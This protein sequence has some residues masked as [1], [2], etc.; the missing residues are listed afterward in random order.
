MSRNILL[1][2]V[3]VVS[4]VWSGGALAQ[5]STKEAAPAPAPSEESSSDDI[6]VT[7]FR[8]SL[9][10]AVSI[11]RNEATV[12]D[13]IAADD[14]GKYP[15]TNIAD[16]LQRV[17]G[18]QITRDRG[19]GGTISVRGL[20]PSFVNTQLNGRTLLSGDGRTFSFL[21]LSPDF[22]NSVVVQKSPTASMLDGG[23]SA[24]VDIRT[25][26]PLDVG[27]TSVSMRAEGVYD[28]QRDK[29]GPRASAVG[30]YVNNDRTF[31]I[32]IGAGYEKT[33]NRSY[34]YLAYGAETANE[35]A[36]QPNLDY[37]LDG[38]STDIYAFDHAQSYYVST[39]SRER[40]SGILGLQ[41]RP[42][43][44]VEFYADGFYSR[45]TDDDDRWDAAVRYT[46]IAP[47]RA[48]AP[49]GVRASTIDTSFNDQLLGRAQGFITKLDADGV[50][51]RADRQPVHRDYKIASGAVGTKVDLG[52]LKVNIEGDYSSG[53]FERE[54]HVASAMARASVAISRPDGI[55]GLPQQTF[56]RGFDPLN[57]SNFNLV[58]IIRSRN[59]SFDRNYSGR[60]N[61]SYDAGEGFVRTLRAGAIHSNRRLQTHVYDGSISAAALATA[62]G[63]QYTLNRSIENGS[64]SA[65]PFLTKVTSDPSIPNW[66]GTYL[67]FDYDKLFGA[68]PLDKVN[69]VAP[70]NE[71][72]ASRLDVVE[73]TT[74]AYA[75]VDFAG[76]D[77]RLSGN[78]GAR[79]VSTRLVS[80]GF[81]ADLDNLTLS[82]DGVSTLVP[83]AGQLTERNSYD[84][85]LP[86]LNLRYDVTDRFTTRLA[87]ARVLARPDFAQLG[88]G[89]TVNANV[90]SINAANPSLRPYLSDQIDLSFEYYLPHSG[91][92][93]LTLFNKT[94]DNFI[95]NGQVLDV[96]QVRRGDGST[97]PLTFRRNQ[98]RNLTT[99]RVM[100]LEAGAQ[101]P[102][103]VLSPSLEGLGVFGNATLIDAPLVPA[104][105]NGLAFPL[106]G[107]SDFSYN[108]GGY[109]ER[110]G[111]GARAYYNWRGKYDTGAENYFGD[112]QIQTAFGQMDG[113]LSYTINE[114]MSV[115]LDFENILNRE[116]RQ[117]NNFGLARGYLLTGRRFTLGVTGRF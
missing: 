36:K 107:V 109:F 116:Q 34:S 25:P 69:A 42:T 11:K 113:S 62:S 73:K 110:H 85:V 27:R 89:L 112:R 28:G 33:F 50:D 23:L 100:G 10:R 20:T 66:M 93:S 74:A 117:V 80:R 16:S 78:I 60:I 94:I 55:G 18:V 7:G 8:Q 30:N 49:Y 99:V 86:S 19:Q 44:N 83:A 91:I 72:R 70:Y 17:T 67:T 79:F 5:E 29:I 40:Y 12:S 101:V 102:L 95:V 108:I 92:L 64:I 48:G 13:V 90:L 76:A 97:Y 77:D 14:I 87:V 45:F 46:G 104:E 54:V 38:D 75:Q 24:T 43:D 15:D 106:P 4:L 105:Q 88:V 53:K 32:S 31:G 26:R 115:S 39:G 59:S 61:L 82:S 58:Q 2:T 56:M 37:N 71:Q 41:W 9:A 111:F 96:R 103:A 84:Y 3:G 57:A 98:P 22:V 21:A 81:G 51:M 35:G 1:A 6:V 68:I 47:G 114:R 65:A 63:G 52:R